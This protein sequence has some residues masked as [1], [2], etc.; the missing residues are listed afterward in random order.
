MDPMADK[1]SLPYSMTHVARDLL[2]DAGANLDSGESTLQALQTVL[3]RFHDH[4][5]LRIGDGGFRSLLELAQKRTLRR[6][7]GLEAL[8]VSSGSNPFFEGPDAPRPEEWESEIGEG[9]VG[10]LGEAL[11]LIQQLARDQDWKLV[12]LWPGLKDLDERDALQR[13]EGPD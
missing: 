10:L 9:L 4:L 2:V 6:H 1:E 3:S 12:E 5:R 13:P 8:I 11:T 7:P